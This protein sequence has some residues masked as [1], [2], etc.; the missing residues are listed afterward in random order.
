MSASRLRTV[1]EEAATAEGC[2]LKELTVL[3]AQRDPY[4]LDTPAKHRSGAWFAEQVEYALRGRERLHL[5]G[6]H[7]AI[8][9]KGGIVKPN[10][11]PYR[12]TDED[13]TWLQ[14][15][16]S[17]AAR[18]LGYTPF[19][20]IV[21]ERNDPPLIHRQ[22]RPEPTPYLDVG[23]HVEIPSVDELEPEI[24]VDEFRG[25]QPYHLVLFG[26]KSSLSDVLLPI[27]AR[28]HADLYLPTG[29]ISDTLTFQIAQDAAEDGRPLRVFTLADCDPAGHQMPVSIGRK[30]Q[31]LRDL[32]FPD[33][34]FEVRP[35]A[36]TV[37]QVRDFSLPSTPLKETE[38]R[39]SRWRDAF[40]IEQT[41]IDA[42]ATLRPEVLRTIVTDALGPFFDHTLDGRVSF[43]ELEWIEAAQAELRSRADA[44]TLEIIRD[45]AERRLEELREEIEELNRALRQAVPDD[46]ELPPIEIPE[47]LVDEEEY[48][49][50]LISSAWPW[51]EQTRALVARK[52]Y[53][54]A[55]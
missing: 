27:A 8:V 4:R 42:L 54:R 36:L 25:H 9:S 19:D 5:R 39:A 55:A 48:G 26:E 45:L 17:K 24:W 51:A 23:L 40:G 13:W 46:L 34:D 28:F 15:H 47:P 37:N 11:K 14:E 43:A 2:S 22:P 44:P 10:G 29:E 35:V 32:Y 3:A 52:A 38:L 16:A 1:V 6:I 50:P 41:E 18:W 12:N 21:D 49:K 30:L 53:E 20:R 7:Y 31:A 33:L